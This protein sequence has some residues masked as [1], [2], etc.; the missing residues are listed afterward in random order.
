[1]IRF[2]GKD[3]GGGVDERKERFEKV[4]RVKENECS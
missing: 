2:K 1:L 3:A 4:K